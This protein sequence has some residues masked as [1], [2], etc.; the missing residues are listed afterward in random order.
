VLAVCVGAIAMLENTLGRAH[1]L[2]SFHEP[3]PGCDER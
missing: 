3:L 1:V 2:A